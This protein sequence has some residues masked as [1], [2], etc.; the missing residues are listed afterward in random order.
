MT[1]NALQPELCQRYLLGELTEAEQ[2]A[3]E[4]VYFAD[5]ER[6][7]EIWAA[8]N[9][10]I[11]RYVRGQLS[12]QE[13]ARFETHFLAAPEHQE[14]VLAAQAILRAADAYQPGLATLATPATQE[15]ESRDSVRPAV[16]WWAPIKAWFQV[17]PLLQPGLAL[18]TLCLVGLTFWLWFDRTRLRQELAQA[19][20]SQNSATKREQELAQQLAIEK[21]RNDQ[22]AARIPQSATSPTP[23]QADKPASVFAFLLS[24][25]LVRSGAAPQRIVPPQSTT[26]IRLQM[27]IVPDP[28]VASY[29]VTIRT[30][31]GATVLTQSNLRARSNQT[32]ISLTVPKLKLPANE[33]LLTLEAVTAAGDVEELNRYF[34][35]IAP[36]K[37]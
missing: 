21:A 27:T 36:P 24:P 15:G 3:L 20:N 31:E 16:A 30:V 5:P 1:E 2:L 18:A 26:E 19:S 8:E 10:L 14:Q 29:Q 4:Q 28:A 22:L 32:L 17:R 34:F 9:E 13:R 25:L 23:P 6:F 33:Y 11:D 7:E 12:P 35:R 37:N